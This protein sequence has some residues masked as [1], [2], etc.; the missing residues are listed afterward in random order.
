MHVASPAGQLLLH[1]DMISARVAQEIGRAII[2]VHAG[3][4][5]LERLGEPTRR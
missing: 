2:V 4:R 5:S 1:Y 3:K